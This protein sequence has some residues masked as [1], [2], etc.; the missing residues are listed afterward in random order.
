MEKIILFMFS[1]MLSVISI[2]YYEWSDKNKL[3]KKYLHGLLRKQE[4]ENNTIRK[5]L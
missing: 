4:K 5:S 1:I 2:G 3:E